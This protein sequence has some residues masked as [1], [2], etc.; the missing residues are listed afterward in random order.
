MNNLFSDKVT[1]TNNPYGSGSLNTVVLNG[2]YQ[3]HNG[4]PVY[5]FDNKDDNLFFFDSNLL[6]NVEITKIQF[7]TLTTDPAALDIQ[8]RF[9]MWG[10]LNFDTM[11]APASGEGKQIIRLILFLLGSQ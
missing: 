7:N 9:T 6:T 8:S 4:T 3:D 10:Y 5:V 2:T 11:I 1:H